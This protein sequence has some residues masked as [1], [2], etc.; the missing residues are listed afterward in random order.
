MTIPFLSIIRSY[1]KYIYIHFTEYQYDVQ[2]F[3][4]IFLTQLALHKTFILLKWNSLLKLSILTELTLIDKVSIWSSKKR[5]KLTFQNI[6]YQFTNVEINLAVFFSVIIE[7]YFTLSSLKKL[8]Q[9]IAWPERE[10]MEMFGFFFCNKDDSRFLLLDY[11]YLGLPLKKD[12]NS[13]SLIEIS[14]NLIN[15]CCT[16]LL[17]DEWPTSQLA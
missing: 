1:N 15:E 13:N 6:I 16:Y 5:K 9:N 11:L 7:K 8:F 2:N 10:I 3:L 4:I 14:Y 17:V 12:S